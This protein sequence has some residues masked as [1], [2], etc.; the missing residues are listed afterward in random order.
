MIVKWV[1]RKIEEYNLFEIPFQDH[2]QNHAGRTKQRGGPRV[3]YVCTKPSITSVKRNTLSE[4][5]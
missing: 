2:E 1:V 5:C 3:A 4:T